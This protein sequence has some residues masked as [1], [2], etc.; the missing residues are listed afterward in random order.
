MTL[1]LDNFFSF[2]YVVAYNN[3]SEDHNLG[4]CYKII[5]FNIYYTGILLLYWGS[6]AHSLSLSSAHH[7]DMTEIC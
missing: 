6:I 5:H 1:H 2:F 7:S 3:S 4:A